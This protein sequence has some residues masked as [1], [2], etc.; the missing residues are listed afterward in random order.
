MMQSAKQKHRVLG[1]ILWIFSIGLCI[2]FL[3]CG[4]MPDAKGGSF[5]SAASPGKGAAKNIILMLADGSGFNTFA[6]ASC[7]EHGE[8]GKEVFNA[9]PVKYA[10]YTQSADADGRV[11]PYDAESFWKDFGYAKTSYTDS[12]AAATA[13]FTGVKTYDR[14][15]SVGIDFKP[16]KTIFEIAHESGRSS[17]VVTTSTLYDASP[18]CAAAH[19]KSRLNYADISSQ[20]ILGSTLDVIM[21][22]GDPD[23]ADPKAAS[24]R[25]STT[26]FDYVG[27][28]STWE[29]LKAGS[30]GGNNPWTL[31]RSKEAFTALAAGTDAPRRV[32]GIP[33]GG[34]D[35]QQ[36][37]PGDLMADAFV[38]PMRPDVPTLATM[39]TGALNVLAKNPK[40]FCLMI[41]GGS[42][43]HAAHYNRKGRLIEEQVDFN[44]AVRT[45]VAWVESRSSWDETLLIVT[46]DHETGNVWGPNSGKT[47]EI[48]FDPV[49]CNGKGKMPLFRFHSGNHTN[50]LVPV[51]A[52]GA[53]AAVFA[54]M[55]R[56]HDPVYGPYIDNT[57][58]FSVMNAAITGKKPVAKKPV[59]PA[60]PPRRQPATP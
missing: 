50:T 18:A 43:D 26:P 25:S 40:G 35:A 6:A 48:P 32:I 4:R 55:V 38:V 21:G 16:L 39:T 2:F 22:C 49:A 27:G 46:A 19:S 14:A 3:A 51:Y 7:Y 58:V 56:D 53:G 28:E 44:E 1:H 59:E 30:A 57:D 15:I 36:D 41:E 45:A 33:A 31:I 9:F 42:I 60:V 23:R 13:L 11:R 47:S 34:A 24:N 8:P 37:R 52:K 54:Q 10:S 17:G 12:A 29:A 5:L 20:M